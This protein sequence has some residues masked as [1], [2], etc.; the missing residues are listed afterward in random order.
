[1]PSAPISAVVANRLRTP[2]LAIVTGDGVD[3]GAVVLADSDLGPRL[4]VA[5]TGFG[6]WL[7]EASATGWAAWLPAAPPAHSSLGWPRIPP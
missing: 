5:L 3:A 1:M 4:T 6:S 2:R 7:R